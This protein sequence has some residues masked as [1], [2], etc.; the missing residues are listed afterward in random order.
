MY[1]SQLRI[2][3]RS[4]EARRDIG[5]PYEMHRSLARVF[6][7][8]QGSELSRYL[9]RLEPWS[10]GAPT[11]LVQSAVQGRWGIL[12]DRRNYL[13][14]DVAEKSIDMA[15]MLANHARFRFRLRANTVVSRGGK[16]MGLAKEHDQQKWLARKAELSGFKVASAM[17]VDSDRMYS[18]QGKSGR[19]I[20][21]QTATF[22]GFLDV[23]DEAAL[24]IS[25]QQGIGPAKAFGCGLLSLAPV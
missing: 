14:G 18:K 15:A 16:R 2:D 12:H 21:L 3:L 4:E 13:I 11:L 20:V 10:G 8:N 19:K 22:E 9:W 17:I 7:P 24:Q 5:D 6:A 23:V 1:L 25:S